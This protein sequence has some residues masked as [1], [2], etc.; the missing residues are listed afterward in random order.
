MLVSAESHGSWV[1]GAALCVCRVV[2][3]ERAGLG[4][5]GSHG[6]LGGLLLPGPEAVAFT[7]EGCALV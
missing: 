5:C 6:S 3:P 1:P 4:P 7:V 2:G